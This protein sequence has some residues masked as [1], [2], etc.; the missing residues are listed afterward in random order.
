MLGLHKPD[1]LILDLMMPN[2]NG[3]DLLRSLQAM[4]DFRYLK[5]IVASALTGTD[6]LKQG[7]LPPGVAIVSKP[8][9]FDIIEAIF[10]QISVEIGLDSSTHK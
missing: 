1:I 9:S 2:M 10:A 7:G 8:V 4:P 3:F 6:I 5:V